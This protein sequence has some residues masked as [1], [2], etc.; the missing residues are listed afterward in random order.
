MAY[1]QD[2]RPLRVATALGKD[3]LLLERFSGEEGVS[4]P[5]RFT[6]DLLSE[7]P[8]IDPKALLRNP[9]CVT[10]ALPGG[11][12]RTVH[13]RINRFA[14]L[15]RR[16]G[17]TAYKAEMVPWLWF[18][19]LSKDCRIFQNQSVSDIVETLFKEAGFSDFKL[20]LLKPLSQRVYCV[21]YRESTLA[22]VSRLLEEEGVFYFFEH[23][24]DA[25]TMVLTDNQSQVVPCPVVSELRVAASASYEMVDEP[26][27]NGLELD[28]V[29]TTGSVTLTS[30]DYEHPSRSLLATVA[31]EEPNEIYDY[32]GGYTEKPDGERYARMRLEQKESEQLTVQGE[33]NCASLTSGCSFDL[34]EH[35]IQQANDTYHLLR[36]RHAASIPNYTSSGSGGSGGG[37]EYSNTFDAIPLDVPYRPPLVTAR[38]LMQGTQTA[39]VTGP[40]GEEIHVD[41]LARVKVHFH[42]DRK[43]KLDENSSCWVR[44]A[45]DWAG[46]GY[47]SIHIPR[48]GIEVIVDFL[49][50]D[51]DQPIIVGQVYNGD[52]SPPYGLPGAG[53]VSGGKSQTHKGKG[54]NEMTMD[55]TTGKE[56]INV[57][58][59]YDMITTVG[60]DDTQTVKNDRTITVDGKHTETVK[61]DTS[62]TVSE[63]NFKQTVT[64]G[65]G[66]WTIN[67]NTDLASQ[68]GYVHVKAATEILLEV[69][70]SKL[71][72]KSDGTIELNGSAIAVKGSA[73]VRVKGGN[74]MSEADANHTIKGALVMSEGS[75]TNTVKGG[76]VML[77][78]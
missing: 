50:G 8:A 6:L 62:V 73:E 56:K 25:H 10:I 78:P 76:M 29:A 75:G 68:T 46:K 20:K 24:P 23:T 66:S 14:Q 37:F 13:G 19:S 43:G 49:E 28:H 5:F 21:Q 59:Q 63:G 18:L 27:V 30:F 15:G 48:I 74:I 44:V 17:L 22:F 41:K 47:G 31:G 58:A 42:W 65:T 34:T 45:A 39:I 4:T 35:P 33:S 11:G 40:A 2:N 55:D 38:P 61:K 16:S 9:V 7:K 71:L 26:V 69:G 77:N 54:A 52:M 64:A 70:G 60:H 53:I 12:E 32:F 1:T 57:N 36:V 67:K 51:P 3:V 72:M